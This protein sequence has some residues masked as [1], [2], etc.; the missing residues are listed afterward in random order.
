MEGK[1]AGFPW[2]LKYRGEEG[3]KGYRE[4][5][6]GGSERTGRK[7]GKGRLP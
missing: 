1:D 6:A 4:G 2:F 5:S 3:G 7:K